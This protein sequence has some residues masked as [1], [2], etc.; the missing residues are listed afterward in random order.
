MK[1]KTND[2]P[3]AEYVKSGLKHMKNVKSVFVWKNQ[4]YK[5]F[6]AI[7][8]DIVES[9]PLASPY[10]NFSSKYRK[11]SGKWDNV[12]KYSKRNSKEAYNCLLEFLWAYEDTMEAL[13]RLIMVID[14]WGMHKNPYT[15]QKCFTS[16]GRK[17]GL[18]EVMKR[19]YSAIVQW[20]IVKDDLYNFVK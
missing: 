13:D 1:Q 5:S 12:V 7:A 4:G 16:T 6:G 18:R 8:R 11:A 2:G 20:N 14:K 10:N 9:E 3:V 17:M 19:A 15:T